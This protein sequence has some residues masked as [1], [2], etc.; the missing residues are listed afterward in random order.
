MD[1]TVTLVQVET[2]SWLRR[3]VRTVCPWFDLEVNLRAQL[4]ELAQIINL[5]LFVDMT[6]IFSAYKFPLETMSCMRLWLFKRDRNLEFFWVNR[7]RGN[8]KL[9]SCSLDAPPNRLDCVLSIC[10]LDTWCPKLW[11]FGN[12]LDYFLN[13]NDTSISVIQ[14]FKLY[15]L[16]LLASYLTFITVLICLEFIKSAYNIF[17]NW[18]YSGPRI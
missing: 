5:N 6:C 1:L 3:R 10:Q 8:V 2:G 9:A 11:H 4:N 14:F 16:D 17:F 18:I 13:C 7:L 12:V 15:L